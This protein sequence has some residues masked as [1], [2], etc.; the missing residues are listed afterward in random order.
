MFGEATIDYGNKSNT[1][2][3]LISKKL[4]KKWAPVRQEKT[5][6]QRKNENLYGRSAQVYG[7]SKKGDGTLM[8][9]T[10]DWRQPGQG[11]T[12]S[13]LKQSGPEEDK[14]AKEKKYDNLASNILSNEDPSNRPQ[15][16]QHDVEPLV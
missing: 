10:A 13:P 6:E 4:E 3:I 1:V 12:N 5:A 16:Y 8:S 15:S 7:T 9:L 2:S 14:N 11:R